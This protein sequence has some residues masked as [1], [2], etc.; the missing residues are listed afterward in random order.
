MLYEAIA[1]ALVVFLTVGG[2]ELLGFTMLGRP[3]VIAP[4]V[5]LLLGDLQTRY[6]AVGNSGTGQGDEGFGGVD[7][8][9]GVATGL[10]G[11]MFA[12]VADMH[13]IPWIEGDARSLLQIIECQPAGKVAVGKAGR[14][15]QS[16]LHQADQSGVAS[17]QRGGFG[18]DRAKH[19]ALA[20]A[21]EA[22]ITLRASRATTS[23][24]M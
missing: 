3:I 21:I 8:V 13:V 7:C 16:I 5:G 15:N 18:A 2:Q 11:K 9:A 4:L 17:G 23:F 19:L 24:C 1:V 10:Q 14:T 6:Q 22:G 20:Q 12:H